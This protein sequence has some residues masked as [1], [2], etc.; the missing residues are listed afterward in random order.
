[1]RQLFQDAISAAPCIVFIG[2]ML[3]P[4]SLIILKVYLVC[5]ASAAAL[6]GNLPQVATS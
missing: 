6:I 5:W 1:M 2:E 3:C 4:K